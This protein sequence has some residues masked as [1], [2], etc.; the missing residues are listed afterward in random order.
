MCGEPT[1]DGRRLVR[2]GIVEDQV[3]VELGGN[4]GVG[5]AQERQTAADQN[6]RE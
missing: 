4:R 5:L 3:D 1:L 6:P 2:G